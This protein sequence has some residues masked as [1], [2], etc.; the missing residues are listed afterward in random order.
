[1][2][3]DLVQWHEMDDAMSRRLDFCFAMEMEG[4]RL[5]VPTPLLVP[6]RAR[7]SLRCLPSQSSESKFGRVL[8]IRHVSLSLKGHDETGGKET[9][10]R[11]SRI[12]LRARRDGTRVTRLPV[13][14]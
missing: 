12:W 1:M 10:R 5:S 6:P 14:A 13:H 8:C 11:G 3:Q 9:G 4:N 2:E 7:V